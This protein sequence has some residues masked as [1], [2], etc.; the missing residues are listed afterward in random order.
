MGFRLLLKC[1]IPRPDDDEVSTIAGEVEV[2]KDQPQPLEKRLTTIDD[3][4]VTLENRFNDLEQ[5][6][7]GRL[8]QIL[9]IL[10]V[11]HPSIS[12]EIAAITD[13]ADAGK[14]G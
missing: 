14:D 6:I 4:L 8:D 2:E 1:T 13:Q 3:R 7:Q 9:S 11:L 10:A 5:K 12:H